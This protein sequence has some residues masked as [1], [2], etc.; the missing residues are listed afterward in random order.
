VA[1]RPR[2]EDPPGGPTAEELFDGSLQRDTNNDGVVNEDDDL[3]DEQVREALAQIDNPD[4]R[5]TWLQDNADRMSDQAFEDGQTFITEGAEAS[6]TETDPEPNPVGV[7]VASEDAYNDALEEAASTA[8]DIF[9]NTNPGVQPN[10]E[11]LNGMAPEGL[12]AEDLNAFV[13]RAIDQGR[14]QALDARAGEI[15]G[16][17]GASDEESR[18]MA[19]DSLPSSSLLGGTEPD[20]LLQLNGG[21]LS[22]EQKRRYVDYWNDA[23]GTFF[24]DFDTD[25][26]PILDRFDGTEEEAQNFAASVL[27][28]QEP[29]I[30]HSIELPLVSGRRRVAYTED[31]MAELRAMGYSND[32]IYRLVRLSAITSGPD[33]I[34]PGA[35]G[36]TLNVA[37]L[38]ALARY[39]GG[40][41]EFADFNQSTQEVSQ[42]QEQIGMN[43]RGMTIKERREAR[44]KL[45]AQRRNF[46]AAYGE[47]E[48]TPWDDELAAMDRIDALFRVEAR[49]EERGPLTGVLLAQNL[50]RRGLE[51]YRGD[52]FLALVSAIDPALAQRVASHTDPGDP[53]DWED[54]ARVYNILEQAGVIEGSNVRLRQL[55][56][57]RG[58]FGYFASL[59][60]GGGGGGGAGPVR[61][62]VDPVAVKEQVQQLWSRMFLSDVDDATVAAITSN[63]QK[64]L[65]DAEEGMSF[66]VTSRIMAFL[67]GQDV[68]NELYRNKPEGLSEEEFQSQYAG[69][70]ADMIGNE[71]DPE[72]LKTGMRTGDYQAAVGRAGASEKLLT[73]STLRGRWAQAKQT[74]DRFT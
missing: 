20:W 58:F 2:E 23:Y 74:L 19:E 48:G 61:R 57:A 4:D 38:A 35:A 60:R 68:Y 29:L 67:R 39:F 11:D 50:F 28:S 26:A 42:L 66:D 41:Q 24:R 31:E 17:T 10:F 9:G 21:S 27:A 43:W 72:A 53:L 1:R 56:D 16:Q 51:T 3:T 46:Q 64:Q 5:W 52:Q 8:A 14:Q 44:E 34:V 30:T 54:N 13:R 45:E 22:D 71:L 15:Q 18:A 69:G 37:P 33:A 73:N 40:G 6:G 65:D 63:L 55:D 7:D 49:M 59:G 32:A 70:I 36:D 12:S 62:L 47:G 25:L